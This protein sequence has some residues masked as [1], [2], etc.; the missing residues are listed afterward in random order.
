MNKLAGEA[1]KKTQVELNLRIYLSLSALG[2]KLMATTQT[3]AY[4]M[5]KS[6]KMKERMT[7]RART[8]KN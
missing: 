7:S 5:M 4:S 3:L 2:A 8:T 6:R 1:T